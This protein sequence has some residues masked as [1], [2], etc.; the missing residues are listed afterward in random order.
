MV[1]VGDFGI[2]K[3]LAHTM[4]KAKTQIG[5][6]YYLSPEICQERPYDNKSDMWAV[7]VVLYE[8]MALKHPFLASSMQELVRKICTG[9]FPS[10]PRRWSSP[11][12]R[13]VQDLLQ[14]D[15]GKRPSVN[16]VLQRPFIQVLSFPFII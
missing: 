10:L 11:L 5:T 8:M 12:R 6:P 2:A 9:V 7:G 4:A 14:K 1:K 3:S 16:E 15:P 13:L